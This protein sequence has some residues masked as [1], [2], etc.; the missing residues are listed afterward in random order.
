[1]LQAKEK[2]PKKLIKTVKYRHKRDL[3]YT[4]TDEFKTYFFFLKSVKK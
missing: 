4:L 3:N 2:M 1:M